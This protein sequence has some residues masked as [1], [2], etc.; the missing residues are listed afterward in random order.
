MAE[1][2]DQVL[3]RFLPDAV[4]TAAV[5]DVPTERSMSAIYCDFWGS[6]GWR[7]TPRSSGW[8]LTVINSDDALGTCPADPSHDR[9]RARWRALMTM[10]ML[11]RF[12]TPRFS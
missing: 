5:R 2:V 9:W 4:S 6:V 12:R 3:A 11:W 7:Y 8:Q 10:R 1:S